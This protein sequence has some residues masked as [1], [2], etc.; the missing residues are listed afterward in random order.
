MI[1]IGGYYPPTDGDNNP[2]KGT[3]TCLITNHLPIQIPAISL[4]PWHPSSSHS[5]VF[6]EPLG[7]STATLLARNPAPTR[8]VGAPYYIIYS[9]ALRFILYP[10]TK[11]YY[12]SFLRFHTKNIRQRTRIP[13]WNMRPMDRAY[14]TQRP[15]PSR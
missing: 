13:L 8:W 11:V 10:Q 12:V 2:K 9:S 15:K 6:S 5:S 3:N 7:Q 14:P 1:P 4:A